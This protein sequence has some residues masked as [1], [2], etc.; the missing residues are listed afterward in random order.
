MNTQIVSSPYMHPGKCASCGNATAHDGRQFLDT[1][2]S[3]PKYGAVYFCSL[4]IAAWGRFFGLLDAALVVEAGKTI[5]NLTEQNRILREENE[6]LRNTISALHLL[7]F[8]SGDDV[9][10]SETNVPDTHNT[11][12][13]ITGTVGNVSGTNSRAVKSVAKPRPTN[14]SGSKLDL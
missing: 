2:I 12:K 7:G 1:G 8:K 5:E 10:V 11:P 4:C 3:I 6:L 14:L 9:S 13:A